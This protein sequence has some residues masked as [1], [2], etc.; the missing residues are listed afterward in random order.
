MSLHGYTG[1][2]CEVDINECEGV[3]CSSNG[4]CEDGV[5]SFACICEPGYTGERCQQS[6]LLFFYVLYPN[7]I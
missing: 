7:K 4:R 5:N 3:N 2:R 6:K 1:D